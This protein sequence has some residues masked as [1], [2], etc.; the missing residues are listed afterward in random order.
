MTEQPSVQ[1]QP[2]KPSLTESFEQA[3]LTNFVH[4]ARDFCQ[5]LE[6]D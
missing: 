2:R 4:A 5:H 6:I 3:D 1:E